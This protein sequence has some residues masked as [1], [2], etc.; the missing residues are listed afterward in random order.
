MGIKSRPEGWMVGVNTCACGTL[1]T[2]D[3]PMCKKC[4]NDYVYQ[5]TSEVDAPCVNVPFMERMESLML[6]F[7]YLFDRTWSICE[8]GIVYSHNKKVNT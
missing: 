4:R 2:D 7:G 6:D 5:V 8:D 3:F 1:Y